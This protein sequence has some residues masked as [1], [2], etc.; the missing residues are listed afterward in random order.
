MQATKTQNSSDLLINLF[1]LINDTDI[2]DDYAVKWIDKSYSES[3]QFY[4]MFMKCDINKAP[5]FEEK[6][7]HP[8]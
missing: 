4:Q 2:L 1:G 3:T 7:M 5:M 8:E 6:N